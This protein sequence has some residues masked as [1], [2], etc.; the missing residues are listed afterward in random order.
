[1]SSYPSL[2]KTV[3]EAVKFDSVPINDGDGWV[4]NDGGWWVHLKQYTCL[5][6]SHPK[7]PQ[8]WQGS[9]TIEDFWICSTEPCVSFRCDNETGVFTV[10]IGGNGTYF[11]S[12]YVLADDLEYAEL[13][14]MRGDG[15][16]ICSMYA[17]TQGSS[18]F[19]QVGCSG[20][21]VL[22]EGEFQLLLQADFSENRTILFSPPSVFFCFCSCF[23]CCCCVL[24]LLFLMLLC[25]FFSILLRCWYSCVV[26]L[27]L[28]LAVAVDTAVRAVVIC[29]EIVI[30][31]PAVAAVWFS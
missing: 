19:E 25:L 24:F 6:G 10:P 3:Q 20:V 14:I 30:A 26:C 15:G 12:A 13:A 9:S 1:M 22:E 23:C 8:V 11:F 29:I 31:L 18:A 4:V 7:Q 27:L 5:C 21:A 16:A 28:H 17:N 2:D